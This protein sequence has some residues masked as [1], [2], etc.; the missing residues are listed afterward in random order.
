[1]SPADEAAVVLEQLGVDATAGHLVSC[2]PI[3]GRKSGGFRSAIPVRPPCV[4]PRPFSNG[5]S[6]P[7]PRRGELVR[8][9]G[10]ELR[11]AKPLLAQLVTLEAGKIRP[12]RPRRSAGDDRHLRF[13]RRPVAP[14]LRPDDRAPS[15]RGHRMMEQ[16]HPLGAG[17]A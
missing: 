10:E 6:I 11:D 16:W 12:G 9:L 3:D 5:A 4:Q 17:A 7:A 1:M 8:L 13:R 14:A 2:S 15:G